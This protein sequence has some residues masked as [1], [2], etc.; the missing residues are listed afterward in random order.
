[1]KAAFIKQYGDVT[2]LNVGQLDKPEPS[3]NQVLIKIVASGVNPVDFHIRNGMMADSGTHSLPLVLGWDCSG[4]IEQI[5]D[6]VSGFKLGD[7]VL[8]FT[9]ISEQGTNAEYI[10]VNAEVVVAKPERMSFIDAAA[11]PLASVTA[12]QGLHTHGLIKQG[13]TVLIHNA[14]GGVGSLA[15]QI[16]KAAGAYVV[17]T[18]SQAKLDYIKTLGADE[19]HDESLIDWHSTM[20]FDLAF[21]AKAGA[22]LLHRTVSCVKSG[23]RIVS[24]FDE[25]S[26]GEVGIYGISFTRMWVEN[27]A[28]DLSNVLSLFNENQLTI[29]IDTVYPLEDIQ[30]AHKR[31]EQYK[32]V[33]KIVLTVD[34]KLKY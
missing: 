29:P 11:L 3:A 23:G 20:R 32:A 26:E 17:A 22:Y 30:L 14:S 4:V 9:P 16:A 2:Q 33:G 25:L 1:M 5:G 13:Q 28:D 8:S 27:N 34:P 31:S 19:V 12:W 24:T 18:A 6:D 7:K 21:V 10:A 15:V